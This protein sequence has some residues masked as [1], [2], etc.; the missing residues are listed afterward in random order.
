LEAE[1]V[2]EKFDLI[3]KRLGMGIYPMLIIKIVGKLFKFGVKSG[4]K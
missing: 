3:S 1:K 4:E 2:I